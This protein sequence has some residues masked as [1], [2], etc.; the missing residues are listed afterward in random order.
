ME[1]LGQDVRFGARQLGRSPGFTFVALL[2]LGLGIRG[3]A[4]I[5]SLIST[6]LLRPLPIRHPVQVF[7]IHQGKEKDVSYSQSMSYPNYKPTEAPA[8]AN[9][10]AIPA[11][12]PL[13]APVTSA[14]LPSKTHILFPPRLCSIVVKTLRAA[15]A[16]LAPTVLASADTF[17]VRRIAAYRRGAKPVPYR[18]QRQP[19]AQ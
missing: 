18:H 2:S 15:P 10:F 3:N 4:V 1:T 5:F 8:A 7:A 19:S 17:D 13:E 16:M 9:P 14:T 6:I 12:M 11:P